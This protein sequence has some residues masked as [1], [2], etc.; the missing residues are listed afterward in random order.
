MNQQPWT[1]HK[2]GGASLAGPA[3]YR[4]VAEILLGTT[5]RRQAAVVSASFGITDRLV[6][7][8]DAAPWDPAA[9]EEGLA[10]VRRH[11]L[12]LARDLL[13]EDAA[14]H[15]E[16]ALTQ[17][18]ETIGAVLEAIRLLGRAPVEAHSLV[19]GFG[20]VWSARLLSAYLSEQG[21]EG[22]WLHAGEV[23]TL[24]HSE[25]GPVILWDECA[26]RLDGRL[27]ERADA[28]FVVTGYVARG[29]DGTP[30]TLGR[31]G[32]DFS[33]SIFAALLEASEVVIWTNVDGVMSG[34]P[35][36][37]A[38]AKVIHDLSYH[39]AMELAYFGARVLHPR[40]MGP[41]V[42]RGIPIFIRNSFRPEEPGTRISVAGGDGA[43]VKGITTI[44]GIALV[45]LEGAGMIG[46]P[47]TA[48]RLFG[49]LREA[50]ISV[51]M[52]SQGSSEH[53]ICFAVPENHADAAAGVAA[54]AFRLELEEGQIQGLDVTRGCAIIAVVGDGMRGT[55]GV[56][57]MMFGA[58]GHAGVNVRAIAQGASERNISAV[59]DAHDATRALRAVHA[60]FYLSPQTLSVGLIGAGLVG[61]ALLDQLAGE[62]PRLR[63]EFSLD[64]RVRGIMTSNRMATDETRLDLG[65]WREALDAEG[66]Q[67]ADLNLFVEHLHAEH[68]PAAVLIDCTASQ[69]VAD[70]YADW[71]GR[72][73]HVITPNK[74][75]NTGPYA[76]YRQLKEIRRAA[77]TRYLYETTVGA[78]LPIIHTLRDLKETGDVILAVE[79]VFSGTLAYL[80]NLFDGSV[81]FSQIV[82][83][84]REKGYTEPDPRDD[85]SGMDVAR[86][87]VILGREMGLELE[88]ADV[89]VESLVPEALAGASVADFLAGLP[90]HDDEMAAR[91]RAARDAGQVLRYVGR[92]DAHGRASA[93]LEQLPADH[94][95][96]AIALT[97]NIVQFVTQRYR[98][99]PLIVRGPGAGPAVTAAGVFSDLLRLSSYL[100]ANL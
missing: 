64:L 78:G 85:L 93:R 42:E 29:E 100:G 72:G 99:N 56:A 9:V 94:A 83:E 84:A 10:G 66:S 70:R 26:R 58:L 49:A 11:H 25:L 90:D 3:E 91:H 35:R 18:L 97:D 43:G 17:D 88:L 98:D 7:L 71:L 30:T 60:G 46:V 27:P 1:V 31:N 73:I 5:D 62:I 47:G 38:D 86:K 61:G 55:P 12:A 19:T 82:T 53:S 95:F 65:A 63:R 59:I 6:A 22:G 75:G 8:V 28:V 57:A 89:E 79:G 67:A 15:Y 13:A 77:G 44:E 51:V 34:D 4:Q 20:E 68:L 32:S 40:T 81:P 39:E 23:L 33:A 74:K 69:E 45:N 92:L 24:R 80:F 36:L 41:V 87:V 48:D 16:A 14:A 52:I 54:A 21:R 37:I 96:A 50:G 76:Y 2:F